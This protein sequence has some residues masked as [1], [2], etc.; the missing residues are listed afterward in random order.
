MSSATRLNEKARF[1]T[2][3]SPK[4]DDR[5]ITGLLIEKYKGLVHRKSSYHNIQII[6]IKDTKDQ[7]EGYINQ[8]TQEI[9]C[10]RRL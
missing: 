3:T 9:R 7:I 4:I 6:W 8:T 2:T 10:L 5:K 1:L